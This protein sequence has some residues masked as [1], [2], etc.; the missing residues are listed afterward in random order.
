M[1]PE[2]QQTLAAQIAAIARLERKEVEAIRSLA[3]QLHPERLL[4]VV[5]AGASF[6]CGM[7]LAR[8][9]AIDLHAAYLANPDYSPHNHTLSPEDLAGISEAIYL[10]AKRQ[11]RVVAELGLPD[12]E[13]WRAAEEMGEHFCGYCVVARMV[14]EGLLEQAF[15]FNYDCGAEAALAAEGFVLGEVSA[16][17]HWSDR[18]RVVA[19]AATHVKTTKD[20]SSFTVYKAN[21]CAVR[22]REMA[23]TNEEEAA[24]EII[25]RSAQINSWKES[26]WS[27]STFQSA[28]EQHVVVLIGFSG[29]DP[30]FSVEL[31]EVFDRVYSTA[32]SQGRP[33]LVSIDQASTPTEIEALIDSGLGGEAP[34]ADVVTRICTGES[35]ATAALLVLM[36]ELL[37]IELEGELAKAE[38]VLPAELEARVAGLAVS[39]PTMSRW[40]YLVS[41]PEE[42]DLIQRANVVAEEGYVPLTHH[43]DLTVRLIAARERLRARLGR[44]GP[45]SPSEAL[46]AHGFLLDAA[47][48]VAYMPVG[49]EHERLAACLRPGPELE[50]LKAAVAGRHPSRLDCVLVSGDGG[51]L[52][53]VNLTTGSVVDLD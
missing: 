51:A 36:V 12:P 31:R 34:A 7:R 53:G 35:T 29:Q 33:R 4:P 47:H 27:L 17:R 42:Q 8:D 16:G 1:Q 18:A 5:G 50:K 49:M 28:V 32:P 38:L 52:R 6:D 44:E 45:E 10:R 15:S 2:R 19:D 13:L 9:I 23:G 41:P 26:A 37:A 11:S 21:G 22:F 14:R 30:K 25:V 20:R 48:G 46:A 24:E 3:A 40:S 43:P 39:A